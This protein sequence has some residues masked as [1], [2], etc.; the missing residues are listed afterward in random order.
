MYERYVTAE[1]FMHPHSP[2]FKITFRTDVLK[3][4]SDSVLLDTKSLTVSV[5]FKAFWSS[6]STFL[7]FEPDI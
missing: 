4:T 1:H 6:V 2:F 3:I 5:R 7:I